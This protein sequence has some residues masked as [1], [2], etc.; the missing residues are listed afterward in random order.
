MTMRS[1]RWLAVHAATLVMVVPTVADELPEGFVR[2]SALA[3]RIEQDIRYHGEHNFVGRTIA[4]Y[5]AGECILSR[6]TAEALLGVEQALNAD[7]LSLKVYDC[8]R[9]ARAVAMFA[10]WAEDFDDLDMQAEFYPRVAK[11]DLFDLGY[12]AHRS[13]HSRG[14]TVDL[15]IRRLEDAPAVR[16]SKADPLS[17]CVLPEGQRFADGI[18]DFGTGYDCF[19]V[20]A[21]HSASGIAPDAAANRENLATLM[22]SHGFKRYAEEWWHYTLA[23]EPFPDTYFDFPVTAGN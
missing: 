2:L 14:S 17:D 16:W 8:Y 12:I 15:A 23:D 1:L 13:G 19:D 6:Q 21:H 10:T 9:P 11:S 4:G 22:E 20:R 18:L 7:G 5:E 3:P